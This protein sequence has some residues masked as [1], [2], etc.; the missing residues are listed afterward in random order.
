MVVQ[1]YVHRAKALTNDGTLYGDAGVPQLK[2]KPTRVFQQRVLQRI[3]ELADFE[4]GRT[5]FSLGSCLYDFV[6]LATQQPD[7]DGN[8]AD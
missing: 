7:A 4:D 1:S 5:A 8:N 2:H 6:K 3:I